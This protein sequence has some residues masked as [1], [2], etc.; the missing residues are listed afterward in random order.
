MLAV[1]PVER[2]S[3]VDWRR[4]DTDAGDMLDQV[5][6]IL[7]R[8]TLTIFLYKGRLSGSQKILTLLL[9]TFGDYAFIFR[10]FQVSQFDKN[11]FQLR[12]ER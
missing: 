9:L 8:L 4:M 10:V 3:F 5:F 11:L 7:A 6:L 12:N 2:I 1:A